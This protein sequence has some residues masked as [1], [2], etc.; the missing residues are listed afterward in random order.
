MKRALW[1]T[2]FVLLAGCSG[3]DP[4]PAMASEGA[5]PATALDDACIEEFAQVFEQTSD[6]PVPASAENLC[7]EGAGREGPPAFPT[8]S[9][10]VSIEYKDGDY[11]A[12]E[13]SAQWSIGDFDAGRRCMTA[14]LER[15]RITALRRGGERRSTRLQDGKLQRSEETGEDYGSAM[16]LGSG[17]G[18]VPLPP[19]GTTS[20]TES[21]PFGVDCTRVA[22]ANASGVS[23]CSVSMPRKCA[24]TR[25]MLPIQI[26]VP[27]PTGGRQVGR[28][29]SL[30]TG[31]VVDPADWEL[32]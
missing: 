18:A 9:R 5:K 28:T 2:P 16:L 17:P 26:D 25:V 12:T 14:V 10:R 27:A 8:T 23:L 11:L 1:F 6:Q 22:P 13:E 29:V 32:P 20:S 15:T 7:F 21:T 24:A 3:Q 19:D 4:A 30:R 31:S